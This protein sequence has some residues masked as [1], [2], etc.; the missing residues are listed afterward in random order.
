MA[1]GRGSA[2]G[3]TEHCLGQTPWVPGLP[4]QGTE[5]GSKLARDPGAVLGPGSFALTHRASWTSG[6]CALILSG[7]GRGGGAKSKSLCPLPHPPPGARASRP[8]R[9]TCPRPSHWL[10]PG[11]WVPSW[12]IKLIGCGEQDPREPW[13]L[14][15]NRASRSERGAVAA[16]LRRCCCCSGEVWARPAGQWREASER[17]GAAE[18]VEGSK[19]VAGGL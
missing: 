2:R 5:G 11:A 9:G 10:R 1:S 15:A 14:Q 6:P 16:G 3:I 18:E 17:W 4:S 19:R 7:Q 13:R 12:E 8:S